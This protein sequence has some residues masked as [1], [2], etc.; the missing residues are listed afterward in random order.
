MIKK[1]VIILLLLGIICGLLAGCEEIYTPPSAEELEQC[2][3]ENYADIQTV[4]S[5]ALRSEY[6]TIYISDTTG[7]MCV[8]DYDRFIDVPIEDKT[9]FAAV[10]RLLGNNTYSYIAIDKDDNRV[11]LKQWS[12]V[13][14]EASCGI[15]FSINGIDKPEV[16]YCTY[17]TPLSEDGWYYYLCEYNKWRAEQSTG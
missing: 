14:D 15:V 13:Y 6:E 12:R 5:F 2:L 16:D 7:L 4:I 8:D 10:K 9:V 3:L 1:L 11:K 17:M